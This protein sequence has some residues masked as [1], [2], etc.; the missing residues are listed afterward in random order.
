[1]II[2]TYIYPALHTCMTLLFILYSKY[3][4]FLES[5]NLFKLIISEAVIRVIKF[6]TI[7]MHYQIIYKN[8]LPV[9]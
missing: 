5:M 8:D 3:V 2:M 9:T 7:P 1:M 4:K 6:C